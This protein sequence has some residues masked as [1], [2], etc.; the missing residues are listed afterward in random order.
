M[1]ARRIGVGTGLLIAAA[2]LV[3]VVM[4][5][6]G[7]PPSQTETGLVVAV[8]SSGLTDVRGFTIRTN[9]GRTVAFRIGVLENGAQFPPGHLLEHAATGVKVVVT[10]RRENGDLVAIRIDDAPGAPTAAP[11]PSVASPT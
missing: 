6:L 1:T 8:D 2:A 4:S 10:Y 3:V 9:D 5:T 7:Q 11:S